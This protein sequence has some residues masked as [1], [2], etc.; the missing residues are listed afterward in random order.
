MTKNNTDPF[1][2]YLEE[3]EAGGV[4]A[5]RQG[6]YIEPGRYHFKVQAVS[7]FTSSRNSLKHFL[8][9]EVMILGC[10]PDTGYT[11]GEIL[12]WMPSVT[13]GD[14]ERSRTGY[15]NMKK[16]AGALA[17]CDANAVKPRE[18]W[19][20]ANDDQPAAGLEIL[21]QAH[22]ITT[23]TGNPFTV[24]EWYNGTNMDPKAFVGAAARP[25]NGQIP[26]PQPALNEAEADDLPF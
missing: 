3:L 9:C 18:V 23:R 10:S 13:K 12:T 8:C 21:A 24:V 16:F 4:Q 25:S 1:L 22:K 11:P 7:Q 15:A 2:D 5:R 20:L 26:D 19:L 14:D 17:G 6:Q